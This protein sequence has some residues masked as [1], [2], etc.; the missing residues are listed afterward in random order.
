MKKMMIAVAVFL[1]IT[2]GTAFANP[3][4][5]NPKVI[6][7]FNTEFV[8]VNDVTWTTGN[9]FYKA[10]FIYNSKYVFAYYSFEGKF[11]GLTRL[12]ATSELPLML[13]TS[14]KKN[15]ADMWVSD[16][17]EV[18]NTDGTTYYLTVEDAEN[19][20]IVKSSGGSDWVTF[21]KSKKQ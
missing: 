11:L 6:K 12:M 19:V 14:I 7:A 1:T 8:S 9:D 17:F 5:V 13:Q 15:Y 21:K 3:T 2:T 4:A 10:S 16:L 20:M 18:A